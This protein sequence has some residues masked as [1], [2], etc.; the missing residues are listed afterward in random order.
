MYALVAVA[1]EWQEIGI[2]CA[3][4]LGWHCILRTNE[5][6]TVSRA[7]I[8]LDDTFTGVV[9]LGWTKAAQW[10]GAPEMVTI[11]DPL[12]GRLVEKA[13]T[14]VNFKDPVCNCSPEHFR[15]FWKKA[16]LHLR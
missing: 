4:C 11:T 10:Q 1:I 13:A 3:I 7:N 2:A 12:V 15:A 8:A 6:L 16:L 14:L 9:N 5:F